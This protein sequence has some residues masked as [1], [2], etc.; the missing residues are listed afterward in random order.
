MSRGGISRVLP[1]ILVIVVMV[2]AV[3]GLISAARNLF[4][5]RPTET[6]IGSDDLLNTSLNRNVRMTVR[7]PIVADEEFRT[8]DIT[9]SPTSRD[10]VLYAGYRER[11]LDSI[12]LNNNTRAYEE[13]VYALDRAELMEGREYD[14][15]RDD[16]RGICATGGL[17]EFEIRDG[18]HTLKR[19]WT[20]TCR[21]ST[22]TLRADRQH[23]QDLFLRQIPDQR[24]V[25]A[26]VPY[27]RHRA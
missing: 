11:E 1:T 26:P 12:R 9:I 18:N 3:V 17:Y 2:I 13:F 19:L 23:I 10:L 20:S 7:G 8:Y 24:E 6:E 4:F 25:L 21:R 27:F 16:V 5:D 22:G 15:E 14:D